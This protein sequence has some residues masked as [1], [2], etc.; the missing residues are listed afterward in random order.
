MTAVSN[1]TKPLSF[2]CDLCPERHDVS[3]NLGFSMPDFINKLLPWDR[4]KRCQISPDWCIVDEKFFYLRGCVELPIQDSDAVFSLGVWTTVGEEEFDRTM[5]F[6][7]NPDRQLEP[8]YRGALANTVPLYE[9]TRNLPTEIVTRA[10]GERP[11]IRIV[12]AQHLLHEQ[13]KTGMPLSTAIEFTKLIL[14]S[15]T[16]N[17]WGHLCER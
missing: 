6:W 5:H 15:T 8:A 12:D 3:L 2:Q 4:E 17:P 9:E 1:T 7:D 10:P 13:Q 16:S 14:H 11:E